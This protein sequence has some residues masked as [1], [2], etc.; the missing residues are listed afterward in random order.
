MNWFM[1]DKTVKPIDERLLNN[2]TLKMLIKRMHVK[3]KKDTPVLGEDMK[4]AL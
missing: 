2:D 3:I 1:S 4:M